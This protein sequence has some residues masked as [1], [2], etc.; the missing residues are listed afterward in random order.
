MPGEQ[1]RLE[2]VG[3]VHVDLALEET[4]VPS[5]SSALLDVLLLQPQDVRDHGGLAVGVGPRGPGST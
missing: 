5:D 2:L 3:E 4:N 1:L